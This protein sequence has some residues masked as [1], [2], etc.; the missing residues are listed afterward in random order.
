VDEPR[1]V[2]DGRGLAALGLAAA[3]VLAGHWLTYLVIQPVGID[4]A[5]LL[6]VT[7]HSYLSSAVEIC[8][9]SALAAAAAAF[10]ARL[11]RGGGERPS[12]PSLVVRLWTLQVLAFGVIEIGERVTSGSLAGLTPA[13]V[14][15]AVAQLVVA[16]VCAWLVRTLLEV[17]DRVAAFSSSPR[18]AP[19]RVFGGIRI[20]TG[21]AWPHGMPV[22]GATGIR[23]P[24]SDR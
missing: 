14:I 6:G 11:A 4:R 13:L 17:A 15:G 10:I 2:R 23:G 18:R 7:G 22:L 16:W 21:T 12:T 9:L 3:G 19:E 1:Q 5:E 24:P 20:P 8:S